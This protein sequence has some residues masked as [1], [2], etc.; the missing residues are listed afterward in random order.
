VRLWLALPKSVGS[1]FAP[2]PFLRLRAQATK[3]L[4]GQAR[5]GATECE[6]QILSLEFRAGSCRT[7]NGMA[8]NAADL[9]CRM[10]TSKLSSPTSWSRGRFPD[11]A[12]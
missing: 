5:V 1:S 9:V 3:E 10:E 7:S 2:S 8:A 4:Q 11:L 12:S 6:I